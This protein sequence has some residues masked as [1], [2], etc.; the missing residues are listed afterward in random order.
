MSEIP[1]PGAAF[2]PEFLSR[3]TFTN[4]EKLTTYLKALAIQNGFALALR[5]ATT[6]DVIRL[7][8]HR[9]NRGHGAKTTKTNCPFR[10]KLRRHGG[11]YVI[12]PNSILEHNHDPLPFKPE[13]LPQ[14]VE[15]HVK[16]MARIGIGRPS[17][18]HSIHEVVGQYPTTSQLGSFFA[19][20]RPSP[21]AS[22]TDDLISHVE[23][24]GGNSI[25]WKTVEAGTTVRG[26]VLT[27]T[28]DEQ[29]NLDLFGDVLFLDGTAIRNELGWTTYPIS[30][31]DNANRIL[32]GGLLFTAFERTEVFYWLLNYLG[33]FLQDK[34]LTIFTDEDLAMMA[35]I[36]MIKAQHPNVHHR[37]CVWHKRSN[38]Q[39]WVQSATHD[40]K[41]V[42]AAL[43]LFDSIV[44]E[45]SPEKVDQAHDNLLTLIPNLAGY[46]DTEV[47]D[48]RTQLTEA[49]RGNAFCLGRR[50]TQAGESNMQ[51][52]GGRCPGVFALSSRFARHIL[53]R[54]PSKPGPWPRR[55]HGDLMASISQRADLA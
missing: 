18:S 45:K 16:I 6:S 15:D 21:E 10:F 5:D 7:Y 23:A 29:R 42:V 50:S 22:E 19:P 17:I 12:M 53:K 25:P 31:V 52:S 40:S 20:D 38:F 54:T 8:C 36:E 34:L 2:N 9:G 33:Q 44:Y 47:Y 13:A 39:K 48:V 46:I 41:V 1:P 32:S 35:A 4:G 11:S 14:S 37:L 43:E 27:L 28:I 30:L 51:C 24:Q 49:Y 55:L 3:L 26:A